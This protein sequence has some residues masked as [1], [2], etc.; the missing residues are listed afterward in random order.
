MKD[1][2]ILKLTAVELSAKICS[3]E[4]SNDK[5]TQTCLNHIKE[6]EP[7]IKAYQ[8]VLENGALAQPKVSGEKCSSLAGVPIA[9]KDNIMIKNHPVT[10]CSKMLENYIAPYNATVIEKLKNAG[11]LLIGK[12]NMDELA[13]GS[14]TETSAF[15]RTN[16]PWD[17]SLIPGGSSGGSAAAVAAFTVPL[18]LGTD[19]GGSIRQPA[20]F[21]GV[22]GFKPSYG[23]VS[24]FGAVALASSLDQIGT[25]SRTVKDTAVL[26]DIIAG[27]DY[28]DPMCEPL[29]NPSFSQGLDEANFKGLKVGVFKDVD[30]IKLD[31]EIKKAYKE[32][33]Q[34]IKD[35]GAEIVE[36]EIPSYQYI[37]AI[38]K[39]IMCA[40]AS[41][42]LAK[43][44]GIRYGY[45]AKNVRNLTEIFEK[46]RGEAL[47]REVKERILFGTFVLS[48]KN[49][50]NYFDKAQRARTVLI[51]ETK[52]AFKKC[53]VLFTPTTTQMPT[54]SGAELSEY[55]DVFSTASN[56]TGA[57]GISVPAGL[58]GGVPVGMHFSAPRLKDA[59]ALKAAAAFE[60]ISGWDSSKLPSALG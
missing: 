49:Y 59:D 32:N 41:A 8:L 34:K 19:T 47:G 15:M 6:V 51:N 43:F 16:N 5:V 11:T 46:S 38:Y 21:C 40:E 56:L 52:E 2:D 30:Y 57:S 12:T 9:I 53:N 23:L 45:R 33:I 4:I 22:V 17:L 25:F 54:R 48:A 55:C 50:H 13:M 10:A 36:L 20:A 3:G 37:P 60:K 31:P 39:I 44:D 27:A 14:S 7:K 35:S 42:N 29:E 28:K 58:L 1:I 26:F 18:A 24:R